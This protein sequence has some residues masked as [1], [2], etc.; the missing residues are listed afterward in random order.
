MV[1]IGPGKSCLAIISLSFDKAFTC[2]EAR[3]LLNLNEPAVL[4]PKRGKQHTPDT[5]GLF[6]VAGLAPGAQEVEKEIKAM[7][8]KVVAA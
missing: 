2:A 4:M 3:D 6:G 1:A 7:T 5:L 8:D